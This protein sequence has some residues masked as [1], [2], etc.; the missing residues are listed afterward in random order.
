MTDARITGPW[1]E[2]EIAKYLTKSVIPVRL[3]LVSPSGWP[4]VVSLGAMEKQMSD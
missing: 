2:E 1:S 3:S 4:V